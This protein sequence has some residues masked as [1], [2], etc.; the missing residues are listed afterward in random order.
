MSNLIETSYQA[1]KNAHSRYLEALDLLTKNNVSC[2]S[3]TG[4]F[5]TCP[6]EPVDVFISLRELIQWAVSVHTRSDKSCL[7]GGERSFMSGIKHI[8]N[9]MKHEDTSIQIDEL[10]RSCVKYKGE[11]KKYGNIG[12]FSPTFSLTCIWEDISH[13]PV[14]DQFITQRKNYNKNLKDQLVTETV[15][16]LNKIIEKYISA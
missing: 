16:K 3:A 12:V 6:A 1:Y 5:T 11:I 14:D 13:I 7:S 10:L 2:D 4:I 8:D 9:M 15:D